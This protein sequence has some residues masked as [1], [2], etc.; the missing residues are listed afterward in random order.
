MGVGW[1]TIAWLKTSDHHHTS[2]VKD[3]LWPGRAWPQWDFICFTHL[4]TLG[5]AVCVGGVLAGSS[6]CVFALL[7]WGI[8]TIYSYFASTEAQSPHRIGRAGER[9]ERKQRNQPMVRLSGVQSRSKPA[10]LSLQP[11]CL[12]SRD[13]RQI[14]REGFLM[15]T[16]LIPNCWGHP[17]I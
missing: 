17:M 8:V 13:I 10:A 12:L 11:L 2:E 4:M 1:A 16:G 6:A 14:S 3:S 5:F 9:V 15:F 7:L